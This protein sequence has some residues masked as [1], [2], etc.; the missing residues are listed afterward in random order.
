[1]KNTK[2][3]K[4]RANIVH[5]NKKLKKQPKTDSSA[6]VM[7]AVHVKT[8]R[9]WS[10]PLPPAEE[11]QKFAELVPDAP[12]RIFKQWEIESKHRRDCENKALR[13]SIRDSHLNR[14]SAMIYIVGAFVLSG[15][16]LWLN[17]PWVGGI[18]SGVTIASVVGAF[19]KQ[20]NYHVPGCNV[21]KT[22]KGNE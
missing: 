6:E 12:E 9:F 16:A 7:A 3:K 15:F 13:A 19:L 22:D 17:L 5:L 18:I 20:R 4:E 21:R 10:G 14:I 1:M 11:I 8:E 2:K